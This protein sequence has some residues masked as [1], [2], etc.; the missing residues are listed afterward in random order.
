MKDKIVPA[1]FA[2]F[3]VAW[4]SIVVMGIKGMDEREIPSELLRSLYE[5]VRYSDPVEDDILLRESLS[6]NKVTYRERGDIMDV[7]KFS[8]TL[9]EAREVVVIGGC[10]SAE[11]IAKRLIK[12]GKSAKSYVGLY[13]YGELGDMRE[14][15]GGCEEIAE[16]ERT[17]QSLEKSV[18]KTS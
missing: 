10:P 18:L 12:R 6:D 17:K 2:V 14:A 9:R 1:I 3:V 16:K 4:I 5:T 15:K 11:E 7:S 13:D 8:E